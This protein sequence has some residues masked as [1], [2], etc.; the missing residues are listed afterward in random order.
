MC[1][2]PSGARR[3]EGRGREG[4]QKERRRAEK[5]EKEAAAKKKAEEKKAK[6]E[7]AKKK[8]D[9]K[10]RKVAEKAAE[11][12]TCSKRQSNATPTSVS[13][14]RKSTTGSLPLAPGSS[15]TVTSSVAASV[16][17][18]GTESSEALI[19]CCVCYRT[20]ADD[21]REETS[22][23]WVECVCTRW[24]HE[25]CIDYNIEVDADGRELIYLFVLFE[26]LKISFV[27]R[28]NNLE[29]LVA[30]TVEWGACIC[31]IFDRILA[32]A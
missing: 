4:K 18:V 30:K 7:A 11:R 17:H 25:Q 2:P 14:K 24:L 9:E 19:K 8:A 6:Q 22:L 5:K 1:C 20:I 32:C 3:K 13:K 15:I 10:A 31:G 23:E 27:Q 28:S 26:C 29:L 12:G 16:A 21:E